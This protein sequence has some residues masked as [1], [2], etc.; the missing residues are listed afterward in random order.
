LLDALGVDDWDHDDEYQV[1]R[2]GALARCTQIL[3]DFEATRYLARVDPKRRG[4]V[5]GGQDRGEWHYRWLAIYV[6]NYALGAYEDFEG[7]DV[8]PH[9]AVEVTIIHKA[10]GVGMADRLHPVGH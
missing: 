2:L 5:I 7:Q 4:E 10:K 6:Q 8:V 9:D 1:T 3:A